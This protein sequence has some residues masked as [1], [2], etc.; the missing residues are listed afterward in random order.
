MFSSYCSNCADKTVGRAIPE[1]VRR[2]LSNH[3]L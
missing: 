1:Y 2:I 3:N